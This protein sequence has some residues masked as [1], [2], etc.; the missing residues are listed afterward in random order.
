MAASE[1][2]RVP[3]PQVVFSIVRHSVLDYALSFGYAL[4]RLGFTH[5]RLYFPN[6][7]MIFMSHLP[8]LG[9]FEYG[10]GPIF[11]VVLEC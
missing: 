6:Q 4:M 10:G 9:K 2:E 7:N 11:K 5:M 1:A 8:L 3:S